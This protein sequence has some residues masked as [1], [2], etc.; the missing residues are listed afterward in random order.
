MKEIWKKDQSQRIKNIKK[1]LNS[2]EINKR[3]RDRI[4][5]GMLKNKEKHLSALNSKKVKT[6]RSKQW[7]KWWSD[8]ENRSIR[9]SQFNTEK[10][11]L[12]RR[13]NK[14]KAIKNTGY[15]ASIGK[16]EKEILDQLEYEFNTGIT[17]QKNISG[18]LVDGYSEKL[19]TVFEVDEDGHKKYNKK[20]EET[21]EKIIKEKLKCI[22]IR[23][24]D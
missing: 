17:R 10:G 4:K 12:K 22:I 9:I 1:S 2:P 23:V 13:N 14:I 15:W 19:N 18:Y 20:K 5:E 3:L 7:K 6:K 11:R 16:N 8:P 21:R 24:E